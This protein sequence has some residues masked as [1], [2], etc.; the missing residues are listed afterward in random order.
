[1]NLYI[2]DA[3]CSR[4]KTTVLENVPEKKT[5]YCHKTIPIYAGIEISYDIYDYDVLINSLQ[6]LQYSRI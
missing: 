4:I 6:Y 5:E 2:Y 1:M 3:I